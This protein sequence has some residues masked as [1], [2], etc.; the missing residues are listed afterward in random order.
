WLRTKLP[1]H[2]LGQICKLSTIHHNPSKLTHR[3]RTFKPLCSKKFV[4]PFRPFDPPLLTKGTVLRPSS[5]S[6]TVMHITAARTGSAGI[7]IPLISCLSVNKFFDMWNGLQ[8]VPQS[9]A[10]LDLPGRFKTS[11][12]LSRLTQVHS[13]RRV[14]SALLPTDVNGSL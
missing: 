3:S 12:D 1:P 9:A 5:V 13:D 10:F 14:A 11:P 2:R 7:S 6:G 8:S 4:N